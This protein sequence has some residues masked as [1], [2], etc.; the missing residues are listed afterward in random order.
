MLRRKLALRSLDVEQLPYY[1]HS[2]HRCLSNPAKRLDDEDHREARTWLAS[3]NPN[4]L[5]KHICEVTFSR[6]SGPGGQSV[7]KYE[8]YPCYCC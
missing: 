6:S 7:N 2:V 8:S 5:P 4:T 1:I 3:F